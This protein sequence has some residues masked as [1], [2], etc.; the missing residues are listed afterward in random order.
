MSNKGNPTWSP[1][2]K[3]DH[4]FAIVRIDTPATAIT[5]PEQ[6]IVVIKVVWAQETAESEVE[7]L[8]HLKGKKKAIYFWMVTR[9]ERKEPD[10]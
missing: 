6:M 8:I 5:P 4:V 10:V 3:Y 2:R 9:L 1:N 7:R